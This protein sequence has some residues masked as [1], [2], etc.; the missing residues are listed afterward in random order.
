M[1]FMEK[2]ICIDCEKEGS[3]EATR[4]KECGG[5]LW[6]AEMARRTKSNVPSEGFQLPEKQQRHPL[7]LAATV[8]S[9]LLLYVGTFFFLREFGLDRNT[10][11]GLIVLFALIW[12]APRLTALG[13]KTDG[14]ERKLK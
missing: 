12:F 14:R 3:V 9:N 2:L 10:V 7:I 4:C 11:I 6:T 1:G 8:F 13:K 5:K